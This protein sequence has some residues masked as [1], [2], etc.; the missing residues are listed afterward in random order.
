M[1]MS[2]ASDERDYSE[3]VVFSPF[4]IAETYGKKLP[5]NINI[6]DPYT[7]QPLNLSY[8]HYNQNNVFISQNYYNPNNENINCFTAGTSCDIGLTGIDN[9]LVNKMTGETI[10]FTE[11]IF[12]ES[13]KFDRMHYD[14]RFKMIQVTGYTGTYNR[15]S[16]VTGQTLYEVVSKQDPTAGL[17]H[18]LYGGFYQGFYKLHGYDYEILPERVTKGWSVEMVLK[19][20]LKDDYSLLPNE[21]TLNKIYPQNKNTFF[22]LGTRAENKFYHPASGATIV[23]ISFNSATYIP[24]QRVTSPL[25]NC[26]KTCECSLTGITI[27]GSCGCG[28]CSCSCSCNCG[29]SCGC[30]TGCAGCTGITVSNNCFLVYPMSSTTVHHTIGLCGSGYNKTWDYPPVNPG[31]DAYS[32][33]LAVRLSGDPKNPRLC[34]KYIKLTGDC[35]TTGSCEVTGVT[36]ESGYTVNEICSSRGIYDIC[37]YPVSL[38]ERTKERWVMIDVIFERY[39]YL[40]DCDLLNAGGLGDIRSYKYTAETVGATVNVIQP[41]YTHCNNTETK[42]SYIEL[43]RKWLRQKDDRL[44]YLKL[45]VNGYLFM[46][47]ED[48]EEIIPRELDTQKE[49]QIGVPFN[50]SWGGGTQGLRESLTFNG[51]DLP[52][53]PYI[54]DPELMPNNTLSATTLSGSLQTDIVM[55]QN[56][57]GTFMGGLSQFRM[58]SEPLSAPQV[59]H[60][61]RVS[62]EKFDLFDFW[63]P[64]CLEIL[65]ECYF[66]FNVDLESCDFDWTI[67]DLVSF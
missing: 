13:V 55:E 26:I 19:P 64:N 53:G 65:S 12:E 50:I 11:G 21:T 29:G 23:P 34:V 38:S 9:G 22:Y 17:Y 1:D 24:Y 58:Y 33:A 2:L 32:N 16:G 57:G 52:Y 54:Q 63:C 43:N 30:G 51:C 27:T 20:R 60:N 10:N 28:G 35:V 40:E 61:F 36:Y 4:I 67:T 47:I 18:E 8:K 41:P 7:V 48:F 25:A 3:E 6:D 62:R 44:G 31:M 37:A 14:R 46:I 15:F 56:F 59:Q 66:D 5:I 39:Q 42:Q 49:K 45:Y